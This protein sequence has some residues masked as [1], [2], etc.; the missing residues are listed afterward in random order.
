MV[1]M[2]LSRNGSLV[3]EK[4]REAHEMHNFSFFQKNSVARSVVS[5][6]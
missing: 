5:F 1:G 3:Q 4:R 6:A 2:H